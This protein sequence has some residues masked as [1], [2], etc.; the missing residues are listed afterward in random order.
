MCPLFCPSGANNRYV[1]DVDGYN[2]T[3]ARMRQCK[4][5]KVNSLWELSVTVL[6]DEDLW[7]V[8]VFTTGKTTRGASSLHLFPYSSTRS[9]YTKHH[10][11]IDKIL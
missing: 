11:G 8:I 10:P 2:G 9:A 7:N 4:Q 1:I 6:G 5:S 3:S